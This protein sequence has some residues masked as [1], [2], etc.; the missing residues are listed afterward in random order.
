MSNF[1]FD[2]IRQ[3]KELALLVVFAFFIRLVGVS[4]SLP[5]VY[6][7]DEP[8]VVR[9]TIMLRD[10]LNPGH[11][12]WP[13]FYYYINGVFYIVFVFIRSILEVFSLQNIFLYLWQD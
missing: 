12:D 13:H 10:S 5:F 7:V 11:F 9:S 3:N 6:N 1:G 2:L 4:H 8:T